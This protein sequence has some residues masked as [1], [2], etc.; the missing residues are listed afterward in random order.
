MPR[1]SIV[2]GD[3]EPPG[4][5]PAAP[6]VGRESCVDTLARAVA[7]A[8]AGRFA[9][10]EVCGEAGMGKS[11]VLAEAGRL[12]R[13]A[14]FQ[15]CS[16]Q[17]TRFEQEVPL[18]LFADVLPDPLPVPAGKLAERMH[19]YAAVR[20]HL[21]DSG[22][23]LA[24]VLDD[25][26][27]ADRSSL[28]LTEYLIRHPPDGPVLV[29]VAFRG[30]HSHHSWVVD[31]ISRAG[32]GVWRIRLDPLRERDLRTFAPH[33]SDRRRHLLM[34][35]SRGNPRYLRMLAGLP[36]VTLGE[37]VRPRGD[38][39]PDRIEESA[40]DIVRVLAAEIAM[41]SRTARRVAQAVAISGD[42]AA[43]DLVAQVARLPVANVVDALDE[44]CGAGLGAMDG[45]W[46]TFQHPLLCVAAR[47]MTGPAWR[48]R[49]HARA[50]E[51]LRS[52]DGPS[53][54]LAHHLERSAQYGDER[55]AAT[56]LEAG[57]SL[58]CR[59]P[60]TAVRLLGKA[61]RILSPAARRPAST[62]RYARA[63]ALAGELD[64]GWD[65][66]QELLR[67]GHPLRAEAATVGVEIARLRGDLD[68]AEALLG[69]TPRP[70]DLQL[71]ALA[72]LRENSAAT[73]DH[74]ER[75]LRRHDGRRPML[76]A[77]AHTLLSWAALNA[78]QPAAA[79][80][81][82]LDAARLVDSVSTITMA[83]HVE[84]VGLLAWVETR[85]GSTSAAATHLARAYEV[86][87]QT[88]QRGALP[89]I[90]VV[91]AALQARLGRLSGAL[92]LTEQAGLAAEHTGSGELRAMANA[93]RL[94]PL[95]W[96]CGP[97]AA[98]DLAG[99]CGPRSP[100]WQRIV[101]LNL[102]VAHVVAEDA[103]PVLDLLAGPDGTW[104]A[105]P[106]ARVLR[107]GGLAQ[108]R[109]LAGDL[110]AASRT[111]DDAEQV[112]LA[113]GL[114]YE[115]G[116]AWFARAHVAARADRLGHAGE[117]AARSAARFAACAAALDEA[118]AHHLAAMC[119]GTDQPERAHAELG[120]AKAGYAACGA[121]WLLSVATRDQR[122]LAAR[123]PRRRGTAPAVL[124]VRERQIA[125]LVAGGLTNQQIADRLFLSRRTVESHLS[126]IFPKLEVRSRVAMARR[127]GG[128]AD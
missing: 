50:A 64:R 61:L 123:T 18:A 2:R 78:G 99:E 106:L 10:V 81:S 89:Y 124:T 93:V 43:L 62:L 26:Q 8:G 122:R 52:H 80:A 3:G 83:R 42:H 102:T 107:L 71:A 112:A 55:A 105:D 114:D 39:D 46:F 68:T 104:P 11:R 118:R 31:A 16:G 13:D 67:D 28:E 90:L 116:L 47:A 77:G 120:L 79:R 115:I 4:N 76:A 69:A 21:V 25:L 32:E 15:L 108:A 37:L 34:R 7:R 128:A 111:A 29:V 119:A 73:T 20:R 1:L 23:R 48:T 22:V 41:L 49:A 97:E 125:D 35:A 59:A 85:L 117:L 30:T 38:L 70:A 103:A 86:I 126:R 57:E 75:A 36:D 94:Q 53:P 96:A 27:W 33:C 84:L 51:Y 92:D 101:R 72:A 109:A 54:L 65:A 87:D 5:Q 113:S 6:L 82:T 56:L 60:A 63:L 74:A 95:L 45:A 110:D 100:A 58:V 121:D 98:V 88:G 12:A 127:L 91:D 24:L 14:G 44:L 17:A 66:L 40:G 9:V 19:G